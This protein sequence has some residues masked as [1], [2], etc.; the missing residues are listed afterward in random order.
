[1]ADVDKLVD[2]CDP[3]GPDL[4]FGPFHL[5][6]AAALATDQVVVVISGSAAPKEGFSVV[7]AED[8]D[9]AAVG[10]GAELV[11]DSREPDV[12]SPRPKVREQLLSGAEV[13]GRIENGRKGALLAGRALL[14][15][16]GRRIV[17]GHGRFWRACR[18]ASRTIR[19]VWS[20]TS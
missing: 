19:P 15:R 10:E 17:S 20:S 4:D 2:L 13:L 6:S 8:I 18:M 11:I 12:L 5:N 7:R 9:V 1:M 3:I 14:G 16:S